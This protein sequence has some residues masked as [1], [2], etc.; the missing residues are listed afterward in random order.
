MLCFVC[1]VYQMKWLIASDIHGSSFY[2]DKLIERFGAENADRILLLGD[3]LYH[4]PRN[5]LP[6]DYDPKK[7]AAAL[8][9]I[10]EKIVCV[11]GNCDSEV[12]QM[13]LDFP[14]MAE[15][16]LLDVGRALLF[17]THGHIFNE[18]N[19]PKFA[20]GSVLL[21]GHFHVPAVHKCDGFLYLNTGSVS[22]PKDGSWHSYVVFDGQR[23]C[24]KDLGSP[25]DTEKL[26]LD[27]HSGF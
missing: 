8:N 25:C 14:I 17:A 10:A 11:R 7:V 4:G 26:S 9:A 1:I 19:P 24:W 12:D 2:C 23:F 22:I 20:K 16:A 13:M 21:C 6:R 5:D 15:Y 18:Q 3:I 27:L